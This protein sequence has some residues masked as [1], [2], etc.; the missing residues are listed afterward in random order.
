MKEYAL[1]TILVNK[2]GEYTKVI[3]LR[4]G[5]YGIT[6]WVKKQKQAEKATVATK[7]VN[8]FGLKYAGASIIK[9]GK[10][11]KEAP[12][13]TEPKSGDDD[14]LD[15]TKAKG[16]DLKAY[17]KENNIDITGLTKVADIREAVIEAS[18]KEAE[19]TEE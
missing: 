1:G 2:L 12:K 5:I 15:L 4:N 9:K 14:V 3:S 8:K 19:E 6:G 16:D 17:A 7:F 18:Q 10:V 13:E 11:S